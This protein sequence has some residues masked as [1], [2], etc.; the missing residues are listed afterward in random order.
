[1][2][3][4]PKPLTKPAAGVIATRPVIMP[5]TAPRNVGLRCAA[6]EHV[7][8]HPGQQRDRGGQVGVDHRRRRHSAPAK[9]G[10]PPLKPF[11]PSHRMP[12]PD[13]G[14]RQVVGHRAFP[15]ARQPRPDHRGR[16]EP[17]GAGR[18]VDHVPAG[19]VQ[20][21]LLGGPPAAAPQQERVDARRRRST[22]AARRAATP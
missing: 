1:M 10:S 6:G 21:A 20:R 7:P 13:R 4:A 8:D 22:T 18:Q 9:Y 5:L 15:V 11:Q 17:G 12:A 14:H 16:D 2:T 19:V 3:I